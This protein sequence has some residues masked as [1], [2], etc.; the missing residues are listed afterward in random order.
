MQVE[1]RLEL[2]AHLGHILLGTSLQRGVR[3][4]RYHTDTVITATQTGPLEKVF[5]EWLLLH[6]EGVAMSEVLT[7]HLQVRLDQGMDM[8][9]KET[10]LLT[11]TIQEV[12]G[13]CDITLRI[14]QLVT[15]IILGEVIKVQALVVQVLI[16]PFRLKPRIFQTTLEQDIRIHTCQVLTDLVCS[17][18]VM[19]IEQDLKII[20]HHQHKIVDMV[21]IMKVLINLV[22]N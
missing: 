10:A 15:E 2:Q 4:G 8:P 7:T 11:L 1:Q 12:Q 18:K 20:R 22:Q 14:G 21:F 16:S 3:M 9:E 6:M 19:I 13:I 17:L 5:Q